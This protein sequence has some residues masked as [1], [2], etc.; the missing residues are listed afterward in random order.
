MTVNIEHEQG[1]ETPAPRN[2]VDPS[3]TSSRPR[4]GGPRTP[5]GKRRSSQNA[6]KHGIYAKSQIIKDEQDDDWLEHMAGMRESFQP[7]D[8]YQ[9]T[10]VEQLAF[11]RWQRHR[12]DRWLTETL[13]HQADAVEHYTRA[14]FDPELMGL[15]ED[16]AAWWSS[17]PFDAH[18]AME[19][20]RLGS[21]AD[22]IPPLLVA[23]F[24]T[25][26]KRATNMEHPRNWPAS[27]NDPTV[28]DLEAVTVRHVLEGVEVAATAMKTD[29]F[30]VLARIDSEID[31]ALVHQMVR[32]ADD[33]RNKAIM[34]TNALVL[35]DA[36]FASHERRIAHLD[37]EYDRLLHRLEV[38]QRARGGALP[39]PIRVK[40]DES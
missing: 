21:P 36:D 20:L 24:L 10:V 13:Q 4:G 15:P 33:Q 16:E 29:V 35:N 26:F 3:T 1:G 31:D 8:Y 12:E 9:D 7:Q 11:N 6:T 23:S 38:A 18:Q 5:D 39:P 28:P 27:A 30:H 32:R 40:I 34:R 37:K 17:D 22:T 25:A 2:Q 19:L 14:S